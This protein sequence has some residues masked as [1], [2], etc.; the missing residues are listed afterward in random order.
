VIEALRAQFEEPRDHLH[1]K[2]LS[3][4]V[5]PTSGLAYGDRA[6]SW[7]GWAHL[8]PI[9]ARCGGARP[10]GPPTESC[11][12]TSPPATTA[13]STYLTGH[14]S[15]CR[16]HGV[17]GVG[18]PTRCAQAADRTDSFAFIWF[19]WTRGEILFAVSFRTFPGPCASLEY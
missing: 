5:E 2:Q 15:P 10:G 14:A 9:G 4:F 12:A 18:W 16:P 3:A 13:V 19:R 17:A 8:E 11:T 7:G 1:I 6:S